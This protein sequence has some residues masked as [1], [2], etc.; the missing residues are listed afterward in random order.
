MYLSAYRICAVTFQFETDFAVKELPAYAQYRVD[1]G[2]CDVCVTLQAVK[3]APNF[4]GKLVY[5]EGFDVFDCCDRYCRQISSYEGKPSAWAMMPKEG[6]PHHIECYYLE[7]YK[8]ELCYDRQIFALI[9]LSFVL[10]RFDA[11]I[12]HA[13][14]IKYMGES[15]LFSAPPQTGKSTQA[16]LWRKHRS[17]DII[18]GD[19]VALRLY[20]GRFYAYGLPFSGTSEHCKNDLA[21][22]GVIVML[23]QSPVDMIELLPPAIAYKKLFCETAMLPFDRTYVANAA[24]ILVRLI[25][26]VPVYLL[27]C[28]PTVKAVETLAKRLEVDA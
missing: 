24:E 1:G 28:T 9:G 16:E 7:D 12:L 2:A 11:L 27:R 5:S 23:E 3:S 26:A 20:D 8:S 22:L 15:T 25:G 4:D 13:S 6:K 14:Y 17:A 10:S 19:R 21:P 18:N